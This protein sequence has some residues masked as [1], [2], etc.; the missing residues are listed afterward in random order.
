[1]FDIRSARDLLDKLEADFADYAN[2]S[3]SARLALNC[4][5]TA[6]HLHEWV[7]G[8]W[9]KS[10]RE[11]RD[12]LGI[13]SP[14][15]FLQWIDKTCVWFPTIQ[16]LT[17]GTKHFGRPKGFDGIRV[18]RMPFMFD[19]P[20]AGFDQGCWDG[21]EPYVTGEDSYLLIDYGSEAGEHRWYPV[22]A[23][24]EAVV[25]FWRKFFA[26]YAPTQQREGIADSGVQ[27]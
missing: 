1:M 10:D 22:A 12:A 21:P 25:R 27:L 26:L 4:S 9:L 5:I 8:D 16:A 18:S 3:D 2:E 14:K 24:L 6:F 23:L 19:T 15:E 20:N 13:Q 7:W 11:T 17:N